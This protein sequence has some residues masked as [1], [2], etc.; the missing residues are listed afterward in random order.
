M[1]TAAGYNLKSKKLLLLYVSSPNRHFERTF[2]QGIRTE[3]GG[4]SMR[5]TGKLAESLLAFLLTQVRS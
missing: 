3:T 2:Y 5:K 4:G 1:G